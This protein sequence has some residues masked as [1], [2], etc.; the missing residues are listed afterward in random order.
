MMNG[1]D[2]SGWGWAWMILMMIIGIAL[3]ALIAYLL[4]EGSTSRETRASRD[5]AVSI[6]DRRLARGEIDETEYRR[7]RQVLMNHETT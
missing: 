5:T 4:L 3:V 7:L 2:M 1:W 6:L